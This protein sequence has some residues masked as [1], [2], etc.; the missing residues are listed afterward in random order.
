MVAGQGQAGCGSSAAQMA[1]IHS[2]LAA[3]ALISPPGLAA[4]GWSGAGASGE[5]PILRLWHRSLT[6]PPPTGKVLIK[7]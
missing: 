3:H 1:S 4:G 2:A 7:R 5:W 6:A